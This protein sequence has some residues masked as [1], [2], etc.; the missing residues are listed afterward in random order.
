MYCNCV[1]RIIQ[2]GTHYFP[3]VS[4]L[5]ERYCKIREELRKSHTLV[6]GVAFRDVDIDFIDIDFINL[7]IRQSQPHV[8][9]KEAG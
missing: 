2:F 4:R 6:Y 5:T 1:G 3:Q 8:H 7:C 9:H